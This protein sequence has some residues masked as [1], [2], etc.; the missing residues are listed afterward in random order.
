[1]Y[2]RQNDYYLQWKIDLGASTAGANVATR[3]YNPTSEEVVG[4]GWSDSGLQAAF[5]TKEW[6]DKIDA[7]DTIWFAF[8]QGGATVSAPDGDGNKVVVLS[9]MSFV[10]YTLN[11]QADA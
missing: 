2:K 7:N 10:K 4:T 11:A 1:M 6:N 5:L 3:F 9:S 8:G